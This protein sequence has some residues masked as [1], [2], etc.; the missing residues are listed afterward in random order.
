M[1]YADAPL[2]ADP[3]P[4]LGVG[5]RR[6]LRRVESGSVP[7]VEV[8]G[9][10]SPVLVDDLDVEGLLELAA[11]AEAQVWAAERRKLR[12]AYRWCVLH[13]PADE[14]SAATWG[15]C[16]LALGADGTPGVAEGAAAELGAAL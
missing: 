3:H 10:G 7:V 14:G 9:D 6:G 12:Y 13:P 4:E 5:P 15:E 8:E 11:E 2:L 1:S 16:D